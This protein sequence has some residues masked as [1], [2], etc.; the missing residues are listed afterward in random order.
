MDN[1]PLTSPLL[2][3]RENEHFTL[4]VMK[5]QQLLSSIK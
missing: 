4:A 2:I 3:C 1:S 5:N